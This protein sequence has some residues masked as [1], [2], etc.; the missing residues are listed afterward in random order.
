MPIVCGFYLEREKTAGPG[1][2]DFKN[3]ETS[4]MEHAHDIHKFE[5]AG[6]CIIDIAQ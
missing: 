4:V 1:S 2:K 6:R 3:G 5:L